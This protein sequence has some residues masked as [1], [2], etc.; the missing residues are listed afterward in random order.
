MPIVARGLKDA[1]PLATVLLAA[2]LLAAVLL[3]AV[4]LTAV[5]LA[6]ALTAAHH[7]LGLMM[8]ASLEAMGTA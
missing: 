3:T 8:F 4:L 1:T 5:L 2:V 7:V 6:A